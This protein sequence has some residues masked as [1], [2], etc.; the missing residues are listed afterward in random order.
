MSKKATEKSGVDG[1]MSLTD[2]L[3]EMRNRLVVCIL[4][5]LVA[6]V[7][8]F[9]YSS[10]IVE[11]LTILGLPA[12]YSFVAISPSETLMVHFNISL[13]S[14]LVVA[15][16]VIAFEI[17]S[18]CS[19]G[20]KQKEKSFALFGMIFGSIFFVI[21]VM[22]AYKITLP[23]MLKF[24]ITFGNSTNIAAQISIEKYVGF[25][26]TIFVIFGVIF[27]LPV[28]SVI[29]TIL[30][31]IKPQWL[32]SARKVMIVLIF[33]IAAIIT[34]PDPTSQIMVAIPII[35]LYELSIILSKI[36]YKFKK[37]PQKSENDEEEDSEDEE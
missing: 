12:G 31:I 26:L 6:A 16:P 9:A 14:G 10:R 37:Q 32:I 22:F 35:L 1:S 25:L 7:V 28:L 23:F 24:L 33:V 30:G 4:V 21:G 13:V 27:E 36:V 8:C 3:K 5:F 11:A 19:P 29:L 2:H 34:P 20:L 18:F 15:V 17:F